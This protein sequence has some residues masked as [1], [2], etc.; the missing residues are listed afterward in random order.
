MPQIQASSLLVHLWAVL[1]VPSPFGSLFARTAP[2]LLA[3]ILNISKLIWAAKFLLAE[4]AGAAVGPGS[5][6]LFFHREAL[7]PGVLPSLPQ[8]PVQVGGS[9]HPRGVAC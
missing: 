7:A 6:L 9:G 1:E 4:G 2:A 8:G 5:L 3:S